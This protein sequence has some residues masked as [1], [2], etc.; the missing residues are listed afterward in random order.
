MPSLPG[1]GC[2]GPGA[3]EPLRAISNTRDRKEFSQASSTAVFAAPQAQASG[4]VPVPGPGAYDVLD[5]KVFDAIKE[6]QAAQASFRSGT[7]RGNGAE[8]AGE[9]PGPGAYESRTSIS[10]SKTAEHMFKQPARRKVVSVHPDLPAAGDRARDR[11]GD[12]AKEVARI[13][14]GYNLDKPGPGAYTQNRDAMWQSNAVGSAGSS[15]FLPGTKRVDWAGKD[16]MLVPGPGGYDPHQER[17]LPLPSVSSAF[18]SGTER[19]SKEDTRVP[20][21]AFYTPVLSAKEKK[22]FHWNAE[23]KWV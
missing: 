1:R 20:G 13:C 9:G 3:Y 15:S 10:T 18:I 23:R 21:P 2:P 16:A 17:K 6:P 5:Q 14:A 19:G 4:S 8:A 22:E 11:L 7:L 12:F